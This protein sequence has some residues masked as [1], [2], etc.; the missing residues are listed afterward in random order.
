ME[1]FKTAKVFNLDLADCIVHVYG[2]NK[3]GEWINSF[4]HIT[5]VASFVIG[6]IRTGDTAHVYTEFEQRDFI[7]DND[8]LVMDILAKPSRI[9]EA[10]KGGVKKNDV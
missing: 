6:G 1:I 8:P 7:H 10:A 5:Y 9:Q 3:K 4:F 2:N